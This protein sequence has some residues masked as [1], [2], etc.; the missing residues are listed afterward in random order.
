MW[1]VFYLWGFEYLSRSYYFKMKALRHT[2]FLLTVTLLLGVKICTAQIYPGVAGSSDSIITLTLQPFSPDKKA[3]ILFE[4]DDYLILSSTKE[5]VDY[6]NDP[7]NSNPW[8]EE[9]KKLLSAC[10]NAKR[11]TTNYYAYAKR[12][13]L[14]D[15]VFIQT[16]RLIKTSNCVVIDKK[17]KNAVTKIYTQRYALESCGGTEYFI[18]KRL[19]RTVEWVN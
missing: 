12:K 4:D 9:G 19:F 13:R 8:K 10:M 5:L 2:S 15:L 6:Y 16:A 14:E 1:G 18:D 7:E 17:T 3:C 11:D